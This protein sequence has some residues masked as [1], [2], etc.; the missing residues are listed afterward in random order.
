MVPTVESGLF[1]LGMV[2]RAHGIQGGLLVETA[3]SLEF[4][5]SLDLIY[6]RSTHHQWVP[7]R[8]RIIRRHH[9]RKRE[10]FFVILEGIDSRTK[11]ETLRGSFLMTTRN[12]GKK[13]KKDTLVHYVVCRH[14]NTTIGIVAEVM[15]T[16]AHPVLVVQSERKKVLIPYVDEYVV[17]VCHEEKRIITRNTEELETLV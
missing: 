1:E 2:T 15:Q 9:D 5:L 16:G 11:A 13:E 14:E 10:L 4:A 12:P 8:A 6:Y 3:V 7:A 17:R